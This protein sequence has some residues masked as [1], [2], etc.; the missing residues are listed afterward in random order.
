[1]CVTVA[2]PCPDSPSPNRRRAASISAGVRCTQHCSGRGTTRRPSPWAQTS[3]PWDADE[4]IRGRRVNRPTNRRTC[5][6]QHPIAIL[7]DAT[8]TV[9]PTTP[10]HSTCP[11]NCV[12]LQQ[13]GVRVQPRA[14]A[15]L[16]SGG[17]NAARVHTER[18]EPGCGLVGDALRVTR[19]A[20]ATPRPAGADLRLLKPGGRCA[21]DSIQAST[22]AGPE[23]TRPLHRFELRASPCSPAALGGGPQIAR[24]RVQFGLGRIGPPGRVDARRLPHR[25][26]ALPVA[27]TVDCSAYKRR[28]GGSCR[29]SLLTSD[30]P[31]R[32]L[33]STG[34]RVDGRA[35]STV[36]AGR[37]YE[38]IGGP[39]KPRLPSTAGA[40]THLDA[41]APHVTVLRAGEAGAGR[42]GL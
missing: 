25:A 11:H 16:S 10:S 26:R 37:R 15:P 38:P 33:E 2:R 18:D 28:H 8:T 32:P 31:S 39:W 7:A 3:L 6:V 12:Q 30:W 40:V 14:A 17:A 4:V 23:R 1:M 35:E 24:P 13:R 42:D 41:E 9:T 22:H 27:G 21:S 19:Y 36:A 29:R 20:S 5:E 34:R